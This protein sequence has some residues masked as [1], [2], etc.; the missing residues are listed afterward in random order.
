MYQNLL[1]KQWLDKAEE[2]FHFASKHLEDEDKFFALICFHFHQAA[3]KYLKSYIVAS[4]LTFRKIHNLKE[5]LQ[6]CKAKDSSF[7]EI[8]E[9]STFL[10]QFYI[11]TRYPVH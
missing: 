11:E 8:E 4:N 1:V 2:D 9:E 5:L 7:S 10:N 3:E 6:I